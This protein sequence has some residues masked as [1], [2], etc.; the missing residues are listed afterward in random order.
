MTKRALVV[1]DM[2]DT[3]CLERDYV[4]SGFAAVGEHLQAY[5]GLKYF[6]ETA[7]AHFEQGHRGNIFNSAL[8]ELKFSYDAAFIQTLVRI[9][10]EHKP[11]IQLLP[12]AADL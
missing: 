3:L 7:T 4:L 8:D 9:Y 2:D 1:F 12:K 5:H 10:R 11:G 6:Y